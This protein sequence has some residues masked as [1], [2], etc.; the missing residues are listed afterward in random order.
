M[1]GI[2]SKH[3]KIE[4][5]ENE[6]ETFREIADK[7]GMSIEESGYEALVKWAEYQYPVD[8]TDRAFTVLEELDADM[9]SLPATAATDARYESDIIEEWRGR[10]VSFTLAENPSE[11]RE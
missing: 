5:T 2:D 3:M 9:E 1:D 10:D 11:H 4:M 7:R 8:P 6:Y